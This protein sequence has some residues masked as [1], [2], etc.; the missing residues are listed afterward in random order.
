MSGWGLKRVRNRRDDALSR[1]KWDRLEVMLADYYRSRGYSVDHCG[2]GRTRSK[3]DGGIDLRLRKGGEYLL[4]QCKH[5]NAYKV[6]HNDVH[7]LIGV[8][9]NNKASGGILVTSGEFTRAAIEAAPRGG[10]V[11]LIDG[12]DLRE[13][14]GPLPEE[15]QRDPMDIRVSAPVTTAA[16]KFAANAAGRLVA[17]AEDRIRHNGGLRRSAARAAKASLVAALAKGAV[18]LVVLLVAFVLLPKIFQNFADDTLAQSRK[19]QAEAAARAA[20]QPLPAP[21][22]VV[23]VTQPPPRYVSQRIDAPTRG[24]AEVGHTMSE[25]E[26]REWRRGNAESM[27]VLEATTKEMPLANSVG[28]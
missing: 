22:E 16:S 7:Q 4:V 13:M 10:L 25:A 2:T 21:Q 18:V 23:S 11:E 19:A 14:I 12:D 27:K 24:V 9:V 17:A 5:W 6:T 28:E 1:V 20:A 15:P 8:V 3:F 26:L